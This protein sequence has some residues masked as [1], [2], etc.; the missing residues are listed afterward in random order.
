M[1]TL[2]STPVLGVEEAPDPLPRAWAAASDA[3]RNYCGW[4]IS[5]E[6]TQTVKVTAHD[7]QLYLPSLCVARVTAVVDSTGATITT[8]NTGSSPG[9]LERAGRYQGACTVTFTHGYPECPADIL[10][11]LA[12][13]AQPLPDGTHPMVS[14]LASGPH[15]IRLAA[16]AAGGAGALT[17]AQHAV[18]APYWLPWA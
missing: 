10:E 8:P 12:T 7:G 15:S 6:L 17:D 16:A 18:L 5:P 13:M 3:I 4:H 14:S 1:T 9:I 2:V 11:L